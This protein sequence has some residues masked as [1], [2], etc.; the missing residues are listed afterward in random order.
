MGAV[1][2]RVLDTA[3]VAFICRGGFHREIETGRRIDICWNSDGTSADLRVTRDFDPN[4]NVSYSETVTLTRGEFDEDIQMH[5]AR[6]N[7]RLVGKYLKRYYEHPEGGY[8]DPD[9][10]IDLN[11]DLVIEGDENNLKILTKSV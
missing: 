8:D 6:F 11:G 7:Y 3:T 4:V 2:T 5:E 10:F 9:Y 1:V